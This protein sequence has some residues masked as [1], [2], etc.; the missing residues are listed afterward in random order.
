MK[1]CKAEFPSL[2]PR[3][4]V[5]SAMLTSP[6]AK[7]PALDVATATPRYLAMSAARLGFA[8]PA[9]TTLRFIAPFL[10]PV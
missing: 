5:S 1:L 3:T 9:K 6:S 4:L 7:R 10:T 2:C 8:L